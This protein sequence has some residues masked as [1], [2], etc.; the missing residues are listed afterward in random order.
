[1]IGLLGFLFSRV[2]AWSLG[3]VLAVGLIGG[4]IKQ[5]RIIGAGKVVAAV[6]KKNAEVVSKAGAA[7]RKS[8]DPA[9]RGVLN[10]YYRTD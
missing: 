5:Q 4:F 3:A 10:P 1:M 6:E 8:R 7:D 9:A 2:G